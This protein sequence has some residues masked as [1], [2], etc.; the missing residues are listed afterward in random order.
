MITF[1]AAGN[2]ITFTHTDASVSVL[3]L[4]GEKITFI[5]DADAS[6]EEFINILEGKYIRRFNTMRE[7]EKKWQQ[8]E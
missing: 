8:T 3:D 4:S 2:T 5:G 7:L 1:S 6:A